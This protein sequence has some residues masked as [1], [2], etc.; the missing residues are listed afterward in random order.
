MPSSEGSSLPRDRIQVSCI[1][2]IGGGF[3]S[4]ELLEK[5]I[6]RERE[7]EREN[8]FKNWLM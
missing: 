3:F 8:D 4:I 1:S 7:E 6:E 2:C 5:P